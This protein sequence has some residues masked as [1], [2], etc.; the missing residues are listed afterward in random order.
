MPRYDPAA[1]PLLSAAASR[2]DTD[3]LA[4]EA[5]TAEL[6]LG[7]GDTK[8]ADTE[9]ADPS[10]EYDRAVLAVVHQVNYQ[11]ASGVDA[12]VF[13][14]RTRG[15]RRDAYRGA[16]LVSPKAQALVDGLISVS[17][18]SAAWEA[19]GGIR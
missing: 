17:E 15:D 16:A 13:T 11:V 18:L 1:H 9:F 7:R 19:A 12:E 3:A 14:D 10:D 5:D 8:L 4:A 2:L 6:L